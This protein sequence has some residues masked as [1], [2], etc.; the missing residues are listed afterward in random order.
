[1]SINDITFLDEAQFGEIGSQRYKVIKNM[2]NNGTG[3]SYTPAFRSGEPVSKSLGTAGSY[4]LTLGSIG[5]GTAS[6]P[7]VATDFLAGI[8]AGGNGGFSTETRTADG[9]VDVVPLVPNVVYLG[10]PAAPTSWDTQAEYDAL[11]GARVLINMSSD[12]PPVFTILA[13][14]SATSGLVVEPLD[15]TKYPGKVAFSFRNGVN[16]LT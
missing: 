3:S 13:S 10:N 1:M 16:Y 15:I 5:T 2:S 7:V 4:V 9:Y 11:V 8:A 12:V 14:D 6:K